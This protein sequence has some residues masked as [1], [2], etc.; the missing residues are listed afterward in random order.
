P[1]DEG[2]RLASSASRANPVVFSCAKVVPGSSTR[3]RSATSSAR[4]RGTVRA[5]RTLAEGTSSTMPPLEQTAS[6]CRPTSLSRSSIQRT[7][8]P[9]TKTTGTPRSSS[10]RIAARVRPETRPCASRRVPSRS[11]ATSRGLAGSLPLTVAPSPFH[12]EPAVDLDGRAV[13]LH[14][15]GD[16]VGGAAHLLDRLAHRDR[17]A[18]PLEHLE[19]VA[20]VTD[21]QRVGGVDP[22]VGGDVLQAGGLGDP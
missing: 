12:P 21:R 14:R 15:Q 22:E 7:G 18:G 10:A 16:G 20:A 11:V 4:S 17:A 19:V 8:R 6:P 13:L 5:E 2:S 3:S 9:V 1:A